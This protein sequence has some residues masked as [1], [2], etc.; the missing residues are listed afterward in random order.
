MSKL[1]GGL[2]KSGLESG[3]AVALPLDPQLPA[4]DAYR[5]VLA[6]LAAAIAANW[7]GTLERSD[8]EFLHDLRI[9]IRRTRTVLGQAKSVL[10]REVR[11]PAREGFA[12]IAGLTGPARD[13]D[14][15]QLEWDQYVGPLEPDTRAALSP[16]RAEIERLCDD[17]HTELEQAMRSTQAAELMDRWTTWLDAPL[18]DS[19]RGD[20][21]DRPVGRLVAKRIERAYGVV[22]DRGRLIDLDTP[23]E[24]VH[25]LR[26]DAKKLRYL[27]ECF[28]SLFPGA[29]RKQFVRRL[30]GLQDNLGEQQDAQV[31]STMLRGIAQELHQA[32]A[33]TETIVAIGH[34]IELLDQKRRPARKGF[35]EEFD[36]FDTRTTRHAL[37]SMISR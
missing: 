22:I 12:W 27:L 4:V 3:H 11:E 5:A 37:H 33:T 30:K 7:D 31:H 16:V 17:A 28:G 6:N 19:N 23:V 29:P 15:Y 20:H 21:A 26:K 32:G 25:D 34:L 36:D 2:V 18:R 1:S 9:A 35:A 13:L 24:Q 14:V 8:S 10:S